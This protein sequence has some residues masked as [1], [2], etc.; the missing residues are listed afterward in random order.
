MGNRRLRDSAGGHR[1]ARSVFSMVRAR[2]A[3]GGGP[4]SL[5]RGGERAEIR[6][7]LPPARPL[8]ISELNTA[9]LGGPF[10]SRPFQT[11]FREATQRDGG[12]AQRRRRQPP[13]MLGVVV[14]PRIGRCPPARVRIGCQGRAHARPLPP[15]LDPPARCSWRRT[16]L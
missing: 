8:Q 15:P 7:L 1:G 12:G 16:A 2:A 3:S 9:P 14:P 5:R 6:A 4:G 11:Q 13:R 10:V